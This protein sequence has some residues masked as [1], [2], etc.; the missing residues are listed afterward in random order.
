MK[1]HYLFFMLLYCQVSFADFITP[2][3]RVTSHVNVRETTDRGD[4]VVAKLYPGVMAELITPSGAYYNVRMPNGVEGYVHKSW[5][6]FV[7][8]PEANTQNLGE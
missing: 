3:D 6:V 7:P 8:E 5:T 1:I 2:S 4:I